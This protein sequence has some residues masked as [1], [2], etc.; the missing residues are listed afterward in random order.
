MRGKKALFV[1]FSSL[2]DVIMSNYY[3]ML[4][5]QIYPDWHI[6]WLVDSLYA[7]VVRTQPWVDSVIEWDRKNT[8]NTGFFKIL[9]RVRRAR[10]D[11]AI[12]M[13]STDRSC[14]FVCLSGIPIKYGDR[15]SSIPFKI[16][17]R[18]L[19]GSLLKNNG[20]IAGCPSYL[21]VGVPTERMLALFAEENSPRRL[22]I[23]AIGASYEKKRWPT[24]NWIQF[25]RLAAEKGYR[26][27]MVG[28]GHAEQ[29]M[30]QEIEEALKPVR[31]INM[32]GELSL[33]E[34]IY[35]ISRGDIAV[36]GDTG[37]LHIARA[38]GV[39]VVAMF[40]PS[41]VVGK[42][43]ESFYRTLF[44]SC[45]ELGCAR[46]TCQKPCL[47]TIRPERVFSSVEEYFDETEVRKNDR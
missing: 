40:G 20:D 46:W 33:S 31:V 16:Y 28:E 22:I 11:V 32:V 45:D 9:R 27:L 36:S 4:V 39:P 13:H 19:H 30:A 41:R 5:K 12:D 25:A 14:C 3:A 42:Y 17:A 8:G 47:E 43:M 2:G 35:V 29:R 44:A 23:L 18:D 7:P 6:T 10:F 26:L 37:P 24:D 21:T 1:R 15:N 38:L 34:L